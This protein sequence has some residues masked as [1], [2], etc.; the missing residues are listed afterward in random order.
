[1]NCPCCGNKISVSSLFFKDIN[2]IMNY[3]CPVCNK[4]IQLAWTIAM[5]TRYV[6]LFLGFILAIDIYVHGFQ[7]Y[8]YT[9]LGL[10]GIFFASSV[11]LFSYHLVCLETHEEHYKINNI[12]ITIGEKNM[13]TE[14]YQTMK[15]VLLTSYAL[16]L[17]TSIM[18]NMSSV[19]IDLEIIRYIVAF[20]FIAISLKQWL[21]KVFIVNLWEK[22][23]T[24]I[25]KGLIL[26]RANKLYN[27]YDDFQLSYEFTYRYKDENYHTNSA[28]CGTDR[29]QHYDTLD[30]A[31]N[32]INKYVRNGVKIYVNPT[33]PAKACIISTMPLKYKLLFFLFFL[34]GILLLV[35]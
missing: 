15:Y 30:H 3:S 19:N 18:E 29:Y 34:L 17:T 21:K 27:D 9:L 5:G 1:M 28:A 11:F 22:K 26:H 16:I 4:P 14:L 8:T 25:I 31:K 12:Q 10:M 20:I 35:I 23:N 24:T 33:N 13:H 32:E 7:A 2:T 6:L